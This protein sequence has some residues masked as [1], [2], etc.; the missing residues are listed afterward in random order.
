MTGVRG[1]ITFDEMMDA[2]GDVQRRKTLVSLLP[3]TPDDI[4]PDIV[5]DS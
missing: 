3:H 2:L 1:P 4:A 5:P